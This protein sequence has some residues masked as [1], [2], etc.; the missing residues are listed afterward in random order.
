[1]SCGK[2]QKKS[3]NTDFHDILSVEVKKKEFA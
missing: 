1:M 3:I 2:Q